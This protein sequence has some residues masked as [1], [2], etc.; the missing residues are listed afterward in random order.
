MI[1]FRTEWIPELKRSVA[2]VHGDW[3]ASTTLSADF[4]ID[5]DLAETIVAPKQSPDMKA[6]TPT[7]PAYRLTGWNMRGY[8]FTV[9]I[10][11]GNDYHD[12]LKMK[13]SFS[14]TNLTDT[15]YE[16]VVTIRAKNGWAK[17]RIESPDVRGYSFRASLIE[18][19]VDDAAAT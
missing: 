8:A 13:G 14:L 16:T 3:P 12:D 4:L 17:Y 1:N 19:G 9:D 15:E 18:S 7:P 2:F 6:L 5:R 11:S 10:V